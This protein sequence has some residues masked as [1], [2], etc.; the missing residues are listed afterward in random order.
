MLRFVLTLILILVVVGAVLA[1]T[2][3][4]HVRN[5]N[6]ETG[7]TVDKKKLEEKTEKAIEKS[8]EAGRKMLDKTSDALHKA[9]DEISSHDR[10]T[11]TT[12]PATGDNSMRQ[13][14]GNKPDNRKL[15]SDR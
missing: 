11:S 2:G 6:D 15:E 9:A 14:E 8:E 5:S 7:V 12:T 4:L 10:N 3:V 13:R 1:L